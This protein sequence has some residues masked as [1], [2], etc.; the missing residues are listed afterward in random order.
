MS[1]PQDSEVANTGKIASAAGAL[2]A[3]NRRLGLILV[4]LAALAWSSGGLLLRSVDTDPW[5]TI[6]WRSLFAAVTLVLFIAIRDGRSAPRL[7][8]A[9][10]WSGILLGVC[11]ATASI[12]FVVAVL[13][14]SVA[15]VLLLQS[16]AP[17][18]AGIM[19]LIFMRERVELRTWIAMAF[20]IGGVAIMVSNSFGTTS[21]IG[22]L[23]SMLIA[24]G[25]AGATVVLRYNRSVRMTPAACLATLLAGTFALIMGADPASAS[26][27]EIGYLALLGVCQLALGMIL[28]TT[29]ARLIPAAESALL[30]NIEV[31]LG[32]F[33]VWLVFA[34]DPGVR[35]LLGGGIILASLIGHSL[36]DLRRG[37]GKRVAP[38]A[39]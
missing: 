17:F 16:L 27:P 12:S 33:W 3:E 6:F 30:A 15:N 7:F 9:M 5:T 19:G 26:M 37:G 34:E 14:T 13:Y 38:P 11:F 24:L 10:G 23:F 4:V 22:T 28:Y 29:G 32:G 20:A 8:M 18:I 1:G 2:P 31:V 39:T 21:F 35:T 36:V 25:F